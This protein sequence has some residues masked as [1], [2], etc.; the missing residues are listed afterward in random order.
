MGGGDARGRTL[1]VCDHGNFQVENI[2]GVMGNW[3]LKGVSG[4][5]AKLIIGLEVYVSRSEPPVLLKP[6]KFSK[7]ET[8]FILSACNS[9]IF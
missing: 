8:K 9:K 1:P 7:P 2:E 3:S 4:G 5:W 6:D